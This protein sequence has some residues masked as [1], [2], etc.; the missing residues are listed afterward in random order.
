MACSRVESRPLWLP[1]VGHLN[2]SG[3]ALGDGHVATYE[4]STGKITRLQ[5]ED[6]PAGPQGLSTHGMDVVPSAQDPSLLYLYMVNH[7]APSV[8]DSA[9]IG[10]DSVIEIFETKVG[11]GVM[12]HRK[13]VKDTVILTPNDVVGFPDG[14]SF[15]F[16]NDHAVKTGLVSC[17]KTIPY[18]AQVTDFLVDAVSTPR[19]VLQHSFYVGRLLSYRRRLQ[20]RCQQGQRCQ[21]DREEPHQRHYICRKSARLGALSIRSPNGPYTAPE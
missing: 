2:A 12:K 7:R 19:A 17:S 6:F 5:L 21:W 8:G 4:I 13:T 9:E 14:K 18:T 11:S 16:T 15:Y 3:V 1:A 20:D 10:A